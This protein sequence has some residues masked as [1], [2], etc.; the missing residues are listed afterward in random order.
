MDYEQ[1]T[2]EQ[3]RKEFELQ[4]LYM[5]AYGG[6]IQRLEQRLAANKEWHKGAEQ[7]FRAI[8]KEITRRK[9]ANDRQDTNNTNLRR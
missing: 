8:D 1:F 5:L 7:R 3:L 6:E 2:D 4:R 9:Q